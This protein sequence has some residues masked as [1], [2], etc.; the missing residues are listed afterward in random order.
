MFIS[1]YHPIHIALLCSNLQSAQ[2]Q[3]CELTL[4]YLPWPKHGSIIIWAYFILHLY[5]QSAHI[6]SLFIVVLVTPLVAQLD[7]VHTLISV[8]VK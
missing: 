6:K 7:P 8:L 5:A 1:L 4:W 2:F 3:P